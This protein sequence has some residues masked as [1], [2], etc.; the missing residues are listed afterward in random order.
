M[1]T[2]TGAGRRSG[3]RPNLK[4]YAQKGRKALL[5]RSGYW[6]TQATKHKKRGTASR[7][8]GGQIARMWDIRVGLGP[9][10]VPT[11][12]NEASE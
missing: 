8:E 6:K 1:Q 11:R 4:L 7:L 2:G 12:T 3:P 5:K 9:P 10:D